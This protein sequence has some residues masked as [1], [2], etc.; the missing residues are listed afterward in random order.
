MLSEG[1]RGHRRCGQHAEH[2]APRQR[3]R[4]G[5]A[6]SN[7]SA[8]LT[9]SDSAVIGNTAQGGATTVGPGGNAF[10]GGIDN[11]DPVG[12]GSNLTLTETTLSG[13]VAVAASGGTSPSPDGVL[14]GVAAGGGLNDWVER[15]RRS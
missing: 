1:Q 11:A 12:I 13:N 15:P 6:I 10:G 2:R 5:G 3:P 4:R 7:V 9:V 8:T 14:L